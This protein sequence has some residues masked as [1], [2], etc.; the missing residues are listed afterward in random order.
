MDTIIRPTL[1]HFGLTTAC[2]EEMVAWYAMV[3]GMTPNLQLTDMVVPGGGTASGAWVT[4]DRANHRIAIVS[5]PGLTAD[6]EQRAHTRLEHVAFEYATLDDLL[7]TYDRLKGL[8]IEPMAAFDHGIT[9]ALYYGDPDGNRVELLV[10]N[11]GDW[12]TSTEFM[13]NAPR[14]RTNPLGSPVDPAK[15]LAARRA[16]ASVAEVHRR[17]AAGEFAPATYRT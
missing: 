11:F 8:G 10:D 3:L 1:H 5:L 4:N 2:L 16:G 13:R 15:M 9:T 14:M 6:P 12:D 7:S 17:A